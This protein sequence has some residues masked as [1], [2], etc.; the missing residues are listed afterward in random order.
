MTENTIE[1]RNV[2]KSFKNFQITDLNLPI[3]KGK[4]TESCKFRYQGTSFCGK[5]IYFLFCLCY[6][7]YG[8]WAIHHHI[9]LPT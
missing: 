6:D 3:K 8:W 1:L 2:S 5:A 7:H 4:K 9:R